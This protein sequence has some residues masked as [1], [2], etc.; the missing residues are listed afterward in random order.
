MEATAHQ[1]LEQCKVDVETGQ[2]YREEIPGVV[3]ELVESCLSQ[4]CFDHVA[5]EPIPS[6]DAVI[7]IIHRVF[8]PPLPRLLQPPAGWMP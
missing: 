4:N 1:E 3:Q 5:P 8:R 2:T 6:R 7:A